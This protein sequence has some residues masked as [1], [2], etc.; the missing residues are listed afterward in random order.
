MTDL[1]FSL[2]D[3]ARNGD[4]VAVIDENTDCDRLWLVNYSML[5]STSCAVTHFLSFL[6]RDD[7]YAER[8]DRHDTSTVYVYYG[9]GSRYYTNKGGRGY[10]LYYGRKWGRLVNF[11]D[12]VLL[13]NGICH[14]QD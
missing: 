8:D 7:I 11:S 4:I 13:H 3:Q 10:R 14:L 5:V 1:I 2:L 6:N 12:I 9:S